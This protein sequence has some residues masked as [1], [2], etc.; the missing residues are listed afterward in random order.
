MHINYNNLL[1]QSNF[2][3]FLQSIVQNDSNSTIVASANQILYIIQGNNIIV[4]FPYY[5]ELYKK[6][7]F[8]LATV[9]TNQGF[10]VA[11]YSWIN[12]NIKIVGV[13]EP[14]KVI[15]VGKK[16]T[17][18]PTPLPSPTPTPTP[19]PTAT[20]T[21]TPT[22]S[23]TP[24]PTATPTPTPTATATPT[25]TPTPTATV[26]PTPTPTPTP[27]PP[28]LFNV[29]FVA[30]GGG[31]QSDSF[32]SAS[33]RITAKTDEVITS[34]DLEYV[35]SLDANDP[36]GS[37]TLSQTANISSSYLNPSDGSIVVCKFDNLQPDNTYYYWL[38][39]PGSGMYYSS[40]QYLTTSSYLGKFR[41]PPNGLTAYSYTAS[42]ASCM[43]SNTTA[44]IFNKIKNYNPHVFFQIG[45]L[46]YWDN[47]Q[48]PAST[49]QYESAYQNVFASGSSYLGYG[50]A[51][52]N[53]FPNMLKNVSI[54]YM[55][56]D[57]DYGNNNSDKTS[58]NK[59]HVAATVNRIFPHV[60]FTAPT[61]TYTS[62]SVSVSFQP[63]YHSWK[64]G[65]VKF[66]FTDN[67]SERDPY[68]DPD[69]PS[70]VVW[71]PTQEAWFMNEMRDTSC[72]VKFWINTFPWEG[73]TGDDGWE[74][75]TYYRQKIA[76]FL[77]RFSGSIGKVIIMSGDAHMS[78]IDD[79]I[80]SPWYGSG[81]RV[82]P[83]M[84][85]YHSAPLDQG[86]SFK[87]GPYMLS[88]S[89][90]F[91]GGDS[92][93]WLTSDPYYN[94]AFTNLSSSYTTQN[95]RYACVEISDDLINYINIDLYTRS[96]NSTTYSIAGD[97]KFPSVNG[98]VRKLRLTINT[99]L[100]VSGSGGSLTQSSSFLSVLPPAP[101]PTPTPT[102]GGPTFTP[103]PTP[104]ATPTP[105]PTAT[106]G[107]NVLI[108]SGSLW[109]YLD[110]GSNQGT[111]WQ[112][113]A[114]DD[115]AW[116]S[117][118]APL[119]YG[120]PMTTTIGYG[121]DPNNKYITYY[122]RKQLNIADVSAIPSLTIKFRRDDGGLVYINGTEVIRSNMPDGS[123]NYLTTAVTP[124]S[125]AQETTY[126]PFAVSSS[127]LSNGN[128]M[129]AVEIHQVSVNSS[130]L[131][132]DIEVSSN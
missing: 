36:I 1:D 54:D 26:T 125:G 102:P 87:G 129:I 63:I 2:V 45:D 4:N 67:R 10:K 94:E 52:P 48:E 39:H 13:I 127:Y 7:K 121:P 41:T 71:S 98:D 56:D 42:F 97:P 66:V 61:T 84:T 34:G 96:G 64:V 93:H 110:D 33:M 23:P 109:K 123:I 130:D 124:Q 21:P 114:Y 77:T 29:L 78:A 112:S 3:A 83:P 72:P 88:G 15:S 40:S 105:T 108:A 120:D 35:V 8:R 53:Y 44:T 51:N 57:H 20:S 12:D 28:L 19:A 92:A 117:G 111:A 118:S 89:D 11:L 60:P 119:G 65:R 5:D 132:F 85:I 47:A 30:A 101:T 38:K 17:P 75:Y 106:P 9:N 122:F 25:P 113:L 32:P 18:N 46:F 31:D 68:T 70:K 58:P 55:W 43:Q 69:T 86:G 22:P 37:G 16:P 128:N 99:S 131:G 80:Y 76:N 107:V 116:S 59:G 81:S 79:G 62:A 6:Y 100:Y 90:I 74:D 103:T 126:Y 95:H 82:S 50:T 115:S 104:T 49:A 24:T 73:T 14:N 27:E 91:T